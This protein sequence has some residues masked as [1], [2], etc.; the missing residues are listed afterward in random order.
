[1][2]GKLIDKYTIEYAPKNKDGIF[3]YNCN[4][5]LLLKDGYREVVY[6]QNP[7][8]NVRFEYKISD[9]K[10]IQ[11]QSQSDI[12]AY[13]IA[14]LNE[15]KNLKIEEINTAKEKAFKE[16]II[17]NG[18]HFDCDDRAQDRTGNRLLLLQAMPVETLEW[19][20][21]N[22]K[23]QS[24]TAQEFQKLCAAIFERIQFIE[25]KTGQFL[26]AVETASDIDVLKALVVDFSQES[27]NER[28]VENGV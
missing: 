26:S 10:I 3:N 22:Y 19:L 9:G 23:P 5:K 13:N 7:I 21:Y 8:N 2:F 12:A 20:D 15:T 4:K 11:Y 16:G 24:F 1:M 25:F 28:T 27:N 17:F 14:L 6:M 18:A